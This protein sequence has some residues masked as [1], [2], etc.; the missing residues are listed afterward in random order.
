MNML[1]Y[2][3]H[4][5]MFFLTQTVARIPGM[6]IYLYRMVIQL[7]CQEAPDILRT[8][9]TFTGW[10]ITDVS[11]ENGCGYKVGEHCF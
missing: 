7:N 9:Y 4:Q 5:A 2:F 11:A 8:G 1:Q 6:L 3:M 10:K